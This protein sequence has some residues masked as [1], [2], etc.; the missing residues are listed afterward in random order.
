MKKY[1][2]DLHSVGNPDHGQNPFRSV[3]GV[4]SGVVEVD[5]IEEA[6]KVVREYIDKNYLGSGNWD[7]GRVWRTED[8][9]LVGE[10]S[11]NGR[12]WEGGYRGR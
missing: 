7:G 6:Q 3:A 4:E 11:Y 1:R 2:V 9:V 10:I 12:F 8:G 5:S